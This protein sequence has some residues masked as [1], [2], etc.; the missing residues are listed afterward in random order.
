MTASSHPIALTLKRLRHRNGLFLSDIWS[1]YLVDND[2]VIP[3]QDILESLKDSLEFNKTEKE[4][5]IEEHSIP[6]AF[7]QEMNTLTYKALAAGRSFIRDLNSGQHTYA[8]V[9]AYNGC[10]YWARSILLILG[11]WIS[12][13]K[14]HE[15]FWFIDIYPLKERKINS[16]FNFLKIGNKQP[17]HA[18]I[19]LT[20]KRILNTSKN[21]SI[22]NDFI[23]FMNEID[24]MSIGFKRNNLQY[25]NPYWINSA[26][27][28]TDCINVDDLS[29]IKDF[30]KNIYTNLDLKDCTSENSLIYF[31][32]ILAR[33]FY[34]IINEVKDKLPEIFTEKFDELI[35]S[36]E[37][38]K[39][40]SQKNW[41]K[42]YETENI[43]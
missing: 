11:I 2:D 7:I 21:L 26:D 3:V 14:L 9:T 17:G 39:I 8:E 29:W 28:K 19:W 5:E 15:S 25:S 43:F 13:K 18:E 23:I 33:N 36:L 41:F 31:Y 32:F 20:L 10:L 24:E 6:T 4:K 12:P 40:L 16:K 35:E 37:L 30:E 38:I 34:F 27:L 1:S 22:D 42:P